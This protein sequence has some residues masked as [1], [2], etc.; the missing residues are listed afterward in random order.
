MGAN[1][2]DYIREAWHVLRIDGMIHI[3]E[4]T[5]R[6]DDADTFAGKL[7]KLGFKPSWPEERGKFTYIEA[8][9]VVKAP[10]SGLRLRF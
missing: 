10:D 8:K 6:F 4:A 5:S 3:W 9:K 1:F 2:T 7:R